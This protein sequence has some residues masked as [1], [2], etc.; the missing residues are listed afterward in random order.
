MY[1]S[2]TYVVWQ[3]KEMCA[4]SLDVSRMSSKSAAI[5]KGGSGVILMNTPHH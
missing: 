3:G 1:S 4:T 5:G 2:V